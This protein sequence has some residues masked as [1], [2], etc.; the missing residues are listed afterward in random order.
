MRGRAGPVF[1]GLALIGVLALAV[2]PTKAVLDQRR[3][4]QA[5]AA[6]L[7]DLGDRNRILEERAA[8]LRTDEEVERLARQYNLVKP[9]EEAYFILPQARAPAPAP[10]P[11]PEAPPPPPAERSRSLWDRLTSWF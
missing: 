3:H 1:A 11:S 9:G 4:R 7:A 10:A 6:Q 2:F 8:Q 5:L